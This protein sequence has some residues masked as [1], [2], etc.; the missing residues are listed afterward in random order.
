MASLPP[1]PVPSRSCQE[2]FLQFV[3]DCVLHDFANATGGIVS[4]TE[5]HLEQNELDS[6]LQTSLGLIRDSA[7]RCRI[8]L[9]EV[10]SVLHPSANEEAYLRADALAETVVRLLRTFLPRMVRVAP[11]AAGASEAV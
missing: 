1:S 6:R 10:N 7:E 11:L 4:L 3:L 2:R 5:H 9:A 8:I